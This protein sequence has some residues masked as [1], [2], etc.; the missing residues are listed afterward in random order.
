MV[1]SINREEHYAEDDLMDVLNA[2]VMLFFQASSINL[3]AA[4]YICLQ[5]VLFY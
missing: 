5:G 1:D 3:S 4:A 2:F